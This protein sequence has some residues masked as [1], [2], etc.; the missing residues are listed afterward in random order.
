[1]ALEAGTGSPT[2]DNFGEAHTVTAQLQDRAS[3]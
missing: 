1:M 2:Y 3:A